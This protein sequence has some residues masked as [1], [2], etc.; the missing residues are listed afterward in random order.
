MKIFTLIFS[1]YLLA[2]NFAPCSDTNVDSSED[3][4]Q[5][6]FSQSDTGDHDHNL[7]DTCSPFCHCHCCHVHTLDFGL[8]IL[9][10]YHPADYKLS[11]VYFDSIGKDISLSLLQ[12]PR[13]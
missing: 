1:F 10:L 2:L 6:E 3:S 9:D 4:T 12:P 5:I 13:V 11:T 7:L 8:N